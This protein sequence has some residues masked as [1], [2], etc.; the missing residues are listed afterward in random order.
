[1]A[2]ENKKK[3][4]GLDLPQTNG[5][6]QLRGVVKGVDKDN[7]YKEGN[8]KNDG[9]YRKVNFGVDINKNQTVYVELFGS[10]EDAV[11]FSKS[12]GTGKER[13]TETEKVDWSKRFDFKKDGYKLIGVNVGLTKTTDSNGKEVNDK[14]IFTKYDA[15]KYI[16]ENLQDDMSVFIRGKLEYSTYNDKHQTKYTIQQASLCREDIDF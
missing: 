16:G 9:N 12:E 4:T 13:K 2:Q 3:K 14:K 1:M 10:T 5:S 8:T 6:F 11:Y 15:C 7:F